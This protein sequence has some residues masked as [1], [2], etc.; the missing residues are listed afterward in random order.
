M[1]KTFFN[2][3]PCTDFGETAAHRGRLSDQLVHLF[4]AVGGMAV[5]ASIAALSYAG[6]LGNIFL[7]TMLHS[8]DLPCSKKPYGLL[9]AHQDF[10]SNADLFSTF[11]RSS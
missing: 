6:T 9:L 5:F 3:I 1:D 2:F 8:H 4:V 10:K 11:T 7:L